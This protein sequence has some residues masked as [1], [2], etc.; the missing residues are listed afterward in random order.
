MQEPFNRFS[1]ILWTMITVY[2]KIA[3]APEAKEEEVQILWLHCQRRLS[4]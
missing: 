4:V 3:T 1:L 2:Y